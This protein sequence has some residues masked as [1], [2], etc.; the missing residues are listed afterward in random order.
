MRLERRIA[1]LSKDINGDI[2]L[3]YTNGA[4]FDA[5][6]RIIDM[7]LETKILKLR[8][9]LAEIWSELT[10]DGHTVKVAYN[11]P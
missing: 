5:S 9:I 4:P 11:D 1:P 3:F 2:L 7:E 6:N 8:D 10:I